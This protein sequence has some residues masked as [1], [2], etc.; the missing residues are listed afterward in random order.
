MQL[1]PF[2]LDQWLAAHEFASPPVQF[3][4]ASSTGPQ[5]TLAEILALAPESARAQFERLPILYAP[6]AGTPELRA[7]V[8]AFHDVDPDW[9]VVLTGASEGISALFSLAAEPGANLVLP[10]PVFPAMPVMARAWGVEVRSYQLSKD[11]GF[12]HRADSILAAVDD[13]TRLVL[14]N[15]PHNPTGAVIEPA[16]L[17]RLASALAEREIPFVVDEVYHPLY[18]RTPVPSAA[19]LPGTRVLGDMSKALS[20][21]G[22]RIGWLIE[23]DARRREQI[24]NARSYFSIASSPVSEALAVMALDAAPKIL[25]RLTSV[26]TANLALFERF[27]QEHRHAI[28][29]QKPGGGTVAFP[30][31]VDGRDSR[32]F[33]IE[34][35]KSGVLVAPGDCFDAPSHFR[36][37][38]GAA[39]SGFETALS[40]MS[41]VVRRLGL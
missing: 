27:A 4:L 36:V 23:P 41:E 9:V 25:A 26:A 35:A 15:T 28:G 13:R 32:P 30:W 16:E 29:W 34:L 12:A 39:S 31:L 22:L 24:V 37:G 20:L 6:P 1:P 33:A 18:F 10:F 21:S 3:N 8:A 2:L 14:V 17:A 38:F 40:R 5:W 11:E 7:R 19:R